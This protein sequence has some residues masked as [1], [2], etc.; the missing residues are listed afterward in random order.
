M[1]FRQLSAASVGAVFLLSCSSLQPA[2]HKPPTELEIKAAIA[3]GVSKALLEKTFR[4]LHRQDSQAWLDC[5]AGVAREGAEFELERCRE[6]MWKLTLPEIKIF[7]EKAGAGPNS[8]KL[9]VSGMAAGFIPCEFILTRGSDGQWRTEDVRI[10]GRSQDVEMQK[11]ALEELQSALKSWADKQS[12]P[13]DI[14]ACDNKLD[15][16]FDRY[17]LLQYAAPSPAK[18]GSREWLAYLPRSY[19]GK[20]GVIYRDLSSELLEEAD[21]QKLNTKP[22]TTAL[23]QHRVSP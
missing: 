18:A 3:S 19:F 16:S 12:K 22:I 13:V 6:G 23:D 10:E 1:N 5:W 7:F 11:M 17:L 9:I 4:A 21:F 20:R 8:G 15:M 14:N 2:P